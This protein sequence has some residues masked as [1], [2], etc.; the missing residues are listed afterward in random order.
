MLGIRLIKLK[1]FLLAI[2]VLSFIVT[3]QVAYIHGI[4][5]SVIKIEK[6]NS[7]NQ[8]CV[9]HVSK[10]RSYAE[11][12]LNKDRRVLTAESLEDITVLNKNQCKN[13]NFLVYRCD[14]SIPCGGWADRQKGIVSSFLMALLTKR[15]FVI[16]MVQPCNLDQF[17]LPNI[18]DW[19]ICKSY[20]KSVPHN[21]TRTF[22]HIE[23]YKFAKV[24]EHFDFQRIWTKHVIFIRF[25]THVID[26]LKNHTLGKSR[27]KWLLNINNEEA[28][29]LVLNTLFKPNE[30]ILNDTNEF[31]TNRIRMKKFVCCHIRTGKNPNMPTDLIPRFGRP[32]ETVLFDFL[33]KY[34]KNSDYFIY[35][36][37]DS[38]KV[39]ESAK[40]NLTSYV[41]INRPIVHV[42]RL[43]PFGKLK[44]EACKGLYTVIL[45][46]F[47]LSLCDEIILTRSGFGVMAVYM[48]G[49][50]K[51]LFM[52]HPIEKRV[53]ATNLTNIQKVFVFL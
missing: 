41:N 38:D 33:K 46:Q 32:N 25:H 29:H 20:I 49:D 39:K 48:R 43:G 36:A 45:E 21:L 23:D 7:S 52:Y 6:N 8:P 5:I 26:G 12:I 19:S 40:N 14:S 31:Y 10:N 17:L 22:N 53:V 4:Y 27:L 51:G 30:W 42:D 15:V 37:S 18:Y 16:D 28:I 35:V 9:N 34:D 1:G 3:V 11:N 2:A 50:A 44:E 47:I 13:R 24:V